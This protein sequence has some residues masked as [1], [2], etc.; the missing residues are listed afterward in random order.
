MLIDDA[1]RLF[2]EDRDTSVVIAAY[3]MCHQDFDMAQ[4]EKPKKFINEVRKWLV[5]EFKRTT[6]QQ[7]ACAI[8]YLKY[9]YDPTSGEHPVYLTD[10]KEDEEWDAIGGDRSWA[11]SRYLESAAVGIPTASALRATSPQLAAMI[12]RAY[13]SRGCELKD[14]EKQLTKDYYATLDSLKKILD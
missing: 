14:R 5:K 7:L 1:V 3:I 11:L 8:E 2:N 13:I 6:I 12:E 4:I 9:G 10:D